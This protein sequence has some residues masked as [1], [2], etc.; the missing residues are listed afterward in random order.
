MFISNGTGVSMAASWND[1]PET[2]S[3][4]AMRCE[5]QVQTGDFN[6]DG[7]TDLI[8]MWV[9]DDPGTAGDYEFWK[10]K[11]YLSNGKNF[12]PQPTI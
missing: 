2:W 8:E 9:T 11:V 6:G 5:R 12:L 1:F 4:S 7:R 10:G 3:K